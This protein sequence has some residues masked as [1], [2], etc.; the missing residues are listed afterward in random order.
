MHA[1]SN[2]TKLNSKYKSNGEYSKIFSD[3]I[4]DFLILPKY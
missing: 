3:N 1:L 4:D 2:I